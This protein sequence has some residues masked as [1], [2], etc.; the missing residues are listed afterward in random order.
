MSAQALIWNVSHYGKL[1]RKGFDNSLFKGFYVVNNRDERLNSIK[2]QQFILHLE[3]VITF[4][5]L[6]VI[7]KSLLFFVSH[8][9]IVLTP[10]NHQIHSKS[11]FL[12]T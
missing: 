5:F 12:I 2:F 11:I 4:S 9:T 10:N 8:C 7:T 1:S 3:S 6:T